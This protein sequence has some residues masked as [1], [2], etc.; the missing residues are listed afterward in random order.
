MI[1]DW[2]KAYANAAS[3]GNAQAFIDKWPQEAAEFRGRSNCQLDISYG[4]R[5]RQVF[6]LFHPDIPSKGLFVFVHGGY[7][8]RFDKSFWSHL[9]EGPLALG[10]TVAMPSYTLA[11]DVRI[12]DITREIAHAIVSAAEHVDG[13]IVL[14]GHSA[15]G[16]LVT[17]QICS[18]TNLDHQILSRVQRVISISGV[19]D[20]RPITRLE[21]NATIGLDY[22]EAT[23]ESP[24]LMDPI[25]EGIP[26]DCIV[27]GSELP[28][29]IRQTD[30]MANVW[31]G[32]GVNCKSY[33]ID[34]THHFNV[35]ENMQNPTGLICRLTD[36]H[37]DV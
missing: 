29:F 16:H 13:P 10:W 7:W 24:A 19:H 33:Q 11:P 21:L 37:Q 25:D 17:R 32:L 8:Y 34:E 3:I 2:D 18:D 27:G 6:D 35:V 31:T 1:E 22:E 23:R 28:E 30:L 36:M 15:G 4:T 12:P 20:L 26:L 9:A 5:E 14:S